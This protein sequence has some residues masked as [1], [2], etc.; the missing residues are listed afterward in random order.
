MYIYDARMFVLRLMISDYDCDGVLMLSG[1]D[2]DDNDNLVT[3]YGRY[4]ID[5]TRSR[6]CTSLHRTV[7][8]S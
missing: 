8:S 2:C 5:Y 6:D 1:S 3:M 7:T 4:P